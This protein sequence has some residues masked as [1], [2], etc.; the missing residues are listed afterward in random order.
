MVTILFISMVTILLNIFT[1]SSLGNFLN[2]ITFQNVMKTSVSSLA[3]EPKHSSMVEW[4]GME[5][6]FYLF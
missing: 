3:L 4:R 2:R 5:A 6:K 1:G